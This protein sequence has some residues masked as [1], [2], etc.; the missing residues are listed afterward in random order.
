MDVL[1]VMFAGPTYQAVSFR[2]MPITDSMLGSRQAGCLKTVEV[3]YGV[4]S[5]VKVSS[6]KMRCTSTI[7]LEI[8]MHSHITCLC[9]SLR[10]TQ[11]VFY[12]DTGSEIHH[13]ITTLQEHTIDI[14]SIIIWNANSNL[15]D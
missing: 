3:V 11:D 14:C 13:L 7:I 8:A 9:T 2:Q 5:V 4:Q 12:N 6:S 15:A 10:D 1:K